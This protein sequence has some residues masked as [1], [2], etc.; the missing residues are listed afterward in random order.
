MH[1]E[2]C[3]LGAALVQES[4]LRLRLPHAAVAAGMVLF[5]RAATRMDVCVEWDVRLV[6]AT[7]LFVAAKAEEAPARGLRDYLAV[8]HHAIEGPARPL[9]IGTQEYFEW[10]RTIVALEG[11]LLRNLGFRVDVDL[12]HKYLVQYAHG[13]LECPVPVVQRAWNYCNDVLRTSACVRFPAEVLA[14]AAIYLAARDLAHALPDDLAWWQVFD[15]D[16]D[17]ILAVVAALRA[18]Y[19]LGPPVL[20]RGYAPSNYVLRGD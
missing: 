18:L 3:A 12:P 10:K 4:G 6:A 2:L 17:D 19:A 8:F 15:A 7:C 14:S 20:P 1:S 9:S 13:V 16:L 11:V 5:Q